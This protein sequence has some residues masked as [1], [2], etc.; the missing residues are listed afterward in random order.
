MGMQSV[1]MQ[2][3]IDAFNIDDTPSKQGGRPNPVMRRKYA[4]D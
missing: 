2:D 1:E 3:F 4:I